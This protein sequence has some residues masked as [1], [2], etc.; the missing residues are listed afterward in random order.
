M[1]CCSQAQ[2]PYRYRPNPVIRICI[3][4]PHS[5][6][7]LHVLRV[8]NP[9]SGAA[10][11]GRA[12]VRFTL[13]F[14]ARNLAVV[15]AQRSTASNYCNIFLPTCILSQFIWPVVCE[16]TD[17]STTI[18]TSPSSPLK[19]FPPSNL[20][21]LPRLILSVDAPRYP[22]RESGLCLAHRTVVVPTAAFETSL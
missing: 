3:S 1:G 9:A 5:Y 20:S 6:C 12:T 17:H 16:I 7:H 19:A 13:A 18:F 14:V 22:R 15:E 2:H 8:S 4:P 10:K 21:P 11:Y